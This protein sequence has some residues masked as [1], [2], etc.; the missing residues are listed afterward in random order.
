MELD[1][2]KIQLQQ[3]LNQEQANM[4]V[5]D[6]STL[7]HSR[8]RG[9][10]ANIKRSIWF[11]II[12]YLLFIVTSVTIALLSKYWSLRVYGSVASIVSVVFV[13]ILLLLLRK[14]NRFTIGEVLPI[15]ENLAGIYD[16]VNGYVK[17]SFRFTLL[18]LPVCMAFCFWLGY[19]EP[20]RDRYL[21]EELL[22]PQAHNLQQVIILLA[23]YIT[24]VTIIIY[25][26][27]QW[28]LGRL[29]GRYLKE[30][31]ENIAELEEEE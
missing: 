19:R 1:E 8:S 7:L 17:R 10:I 23:I 21:L 29:Y 25:Y 14:I 22:Y 15:Q 13:V 3:H 9:A 30:L 12:C 26:C 24:V 31:K 2:L 28:W 18:L 6:L 27:S 20:L 5:T 11:E 4:P 16:I